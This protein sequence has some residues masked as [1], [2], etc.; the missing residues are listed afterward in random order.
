[1]SEIWN[2]FEKIALEQGL[3]TLADDDTENSPKARYDSLSDDAIRLIYGLEPE[4]IFEKD[5]TIIE[6]AHPET[7]VVGLAYDA[8]NSVVENLHQRQDMMAYIALK[9]PNGHLTQRRYV[10]A[11]Q[12]LINSLVRSAFVLDNKEEIQLM[13]LAD[14]CAV[15]LD[16]TA[17]PIA[18]AL[19]IAAYGLAASV[20]LGGAYYLFYGAS[21]AQNVYINSKKVLDALDAVSDKPYVDGIRTDVE[22]IMRMAEQVY[23]VKD[24]LAQVQSVDAAVNAAKQQPIIDSVNSKIQQYVSQLRKV[25]AVIPSWVAKIKVAHETE[26]SE[27]SDWWAKLKNVADPFFFS[28]E[29]TLL[30]R[31]V[32][33]KNWMGQGS[34]GGLYQ[35]ITDD[36]QK[37]SNAI[38]A[39]KSQVQQAQSLESI[40]VPTPEVEKPIAQLTPQS[41]QLPTPTPPP[42][43]T[44]PAGAAR[45]PSDFAGLPGW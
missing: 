19:P 41:S 40:E 25:H 37:M 39:A 13:S 16:K 20:L 30:D 44:P 6:I 31:L 8:M 11:K 3:I 28:A 5:K 24:T 35:A 43:P 38:R 22:K 27:D 1:M 34:S 26:T 14:S 15:R 12:D 23:S 17:A 10:E 9:Q 21:T 45:K 7:A 4:T 18:A 29:E 32:G 2:E 36:I 42:S 33:Q